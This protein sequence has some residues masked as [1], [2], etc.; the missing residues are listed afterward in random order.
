MVEAIDA[1]VVF[2]TGSSRGI[3]AETAVA[4]AREEM[5]VVVT[6]YE[7]AIHAEETAKRCRAAGAP[8]VFLTQLNILDSH[9]IEEAVTAI[10]NRYEKID[11]LVN[12]AGVLVES[13]L[14]EQSI[15]D[16]ERQVRTNLEG[17]IKVTK[18]CLPY[19]REAI[20]NIGSGAGITAYAGL[21]PYSATKFGV[22]GFTQALAQ[23]LDDIAVYV[24]NPGLTAT[25]MTNFEGIPPEKVA[26]VVVKT[27]KGE[28]NA[29]KDRDI[30][31]WDYVE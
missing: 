31:V 25:A 19:V 14:S 17:T 21:S 9:S 28:L 3:G 23:E 15:Q 26:D 27:A 30:N 13:S 8:D 20:I 29:Y 5:N 2:I 11:I 18:V 6:Y 12:N 24:V 10:I 4:F 16:I 1:K 7:E 22:R